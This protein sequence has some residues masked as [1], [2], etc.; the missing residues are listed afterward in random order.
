MPQYIMSWLYETDEDMKDALQKWIED[1]FKG[2]IIK[3]DQAIVNIWAE[4]INHVE[5]SACYK[6]R[7]FIEW[8]D[9]DVADPWIIAT[10]KV[11]KLTV[12]TNEQKNIGLNKVN[13]SKSAK[14]PNICEDFD[15]RCITLREMLRELEFRLQ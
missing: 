12:V 6:R 7:A 1:E 13:P 8:A 4:I 14:I 10:A 5:T 9:E 11:N 2:E 15:V 3:K